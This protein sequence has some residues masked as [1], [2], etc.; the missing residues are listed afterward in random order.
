MIPEEV[1]IKALAERLPGWR[2]ELGDLPSIRHFDAT[3]FDEAHTGT[4]GEAWRVLFDPESDEVIAIR[5]RSGSRKIPVPAEF[6]AA[7]GA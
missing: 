7:G 1:V 5:E 4:E 6:N 3:V 2:K